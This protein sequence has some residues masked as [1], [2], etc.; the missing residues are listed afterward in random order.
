MIG[1]TNSN[2]MRANLQAATLTGACIEAWKIAENTNLEGVDCDYIYL[3]ESDQERRP[4][5]GEFEE[6]EFQQLALEQRKL[7]VD[8]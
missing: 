6:G 1:S 2:V 5:Q 3:V 8:E 4:K 7:Y